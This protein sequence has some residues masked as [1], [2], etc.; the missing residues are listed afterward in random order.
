MQQIETDHRE[1]IKTSLKFY[2]PP[3]NTF[4]I[5]IKG[6]KVNKSAMWDNQWIT[7]PVSG[8]F[9]DYEAATDAII[10]AEQELQPEL[11]MVSINSCPDDCLA[12][13]KNRFRPDCPALKD[14]DIPFI[15]TI[16]L[17]F[18]T[19]RSVTGVSATD[20]EKE[21]SRNRVMQFVDQAIAAGLP[22]PLVADSGNG[23][24][25]TMKVPHLQVDQGKELVRTF[26]QFVADHYSDDFVKV[27][28][29]VCSPAHL[30]RVIGTMN[31]KGEDMADRP[32]R[33]SRIIS[34]PQNIQ[35]IPIE[36]LVAIANQHSSNKEQ[37]A[38]LISTPAR[39][40]THQPSKFDLSA[41][42][43]K[44]GVPITK[45]VPHGDAILHVLQRCLF[46]PSHGLSEAAIGQR[47]DGTLFY[48]CFHDSCQGH[49]WHDVKQLISRDDSLQPFIV[50]G[51]PGYEPLAGTVISMEELVSIDFPPTIPLVE[52]IVSVGGATV[53]SGP[54]GVGKSNLTLNMA[55]SLGSQGLVQFL[56]L[57]VADHVKTLIVQAENAAA[58]TKD[59]LLMMAN[60]PGFQ[61]GFK[62][63]FS[64]THNLSDIRILNGDF[65]DERFFNRIQ[66]DLISTGAGLLIVD[67]LISFHK[68]DE[69]DNST[70]RR[71]LD[72][73]TQLMV[74]TGVAI[75]LVHHVGRDS[76]S[77]GSGYAGRGASAVGD[78]AHNT[79][80]LR[81]SDMK[82][83]ILELSCQKAR[84]FKKPEPIQM[85]LNQQLVFERVYPKGNSAAVYHQR[86]V[87]DALR[88]LGGI[89]KTQ[90]ELVDAIIANQPDLNKTKGFNIVK[91]AVQD[92][93]V[94]ETSNQRAKTYELPPQ[95]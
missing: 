14:T 13:A 71:T 93:I 73:M 8:Y 79:F 61:A 89:A 49:R 26:T 52:N 31:K 4:E 2:H 62:H 84:N 72:R 60:F 91:A 53:I 5:R 45:T 81:V 44:Y 38:V 94:V 51:S 87:T 47:E 28:T 48:Q 9:N 25:V 74:Q 46:N 36:R 63:V 15:D 43:L 80:L 22:E 75:I 82:T 41:Y 33:R 21:M 10:R 19:T 68:G 88:G 78:W 50:G 12:R 77:G 24:H 92:G 3:G 69:N 18:D 67:P 17:D 95:P 64:P 42:L 76:R 58:D 11:I 85:Q 30:V 32:H 57:N 54:G 23:Y 39:I 27:D 6:S 1:D 83:G 90:K 34:L 35:P 7:G 86:L 37:E 40:G 20:A 29:S 66:E 56:D 16:V 70:M 59:R 55:L 65:N